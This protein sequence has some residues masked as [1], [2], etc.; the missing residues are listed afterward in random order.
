MAEHRL[1]ADYRATLLAQ[2]PAA[3]A[4][5]VAGGLAETRDHYLRHGLSPDDAARAALAEF[6]DPGLVTDAFTQASP[7]RRAA[8]TLMLTGPG[9][10]ACWGAVLVGGRAWTWPVPA[11]AF[12]LLGLTL[13]CL[14]ALLATAAFARR[15]RSVRRAGTA[16]CAGLGALDTAAISTVIAVMPGFR[17][18][19]V[20]AACASATRL[21]YLA[22]T[23]RP[24]LAR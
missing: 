16:A 22:R 6:G 14:I 24:R 15:Y 9:V 10:G 19:A 12:A 5:E 13:T 1:I 7:L 3:I 20:L 4:E 8:R 17:W 21:T 2:L 18:L 23:I 11:P